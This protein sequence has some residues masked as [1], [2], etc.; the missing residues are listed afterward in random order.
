MRD[1][2][3]FFRRL[4]ASELTSTLLH[5]SMPASCHKDVCSLRKYM[6]RFYQIQVKMIRGY[7]NWY[8]SLR[9]PLY[10]LIFSLSLKPFPLQRSY[11]CIFS[12]AQH[13]AFAR[14]ENEVQDDDHKED[15]NASVLDIIGERFRALTQIEITEVRPAL[16]DLEKLG[17][18]CP[19][20]KEHSFLDIHPDAEKIC[21]CKVKKG[22][23]S[24][25]LDQLRNVKEPNN[26]R[27]YSRA[28]S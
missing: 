5:A 26:I 12:P 7:G 1:I 23:K 13:V 3:G 2:R 19:K 25:L 14:I 16:G 27:R 15:K 9:V 18:L 6:S 8:R 22:Y 4:A 21:N 24:H 17:P 28:V 11:I 10:I 20:V